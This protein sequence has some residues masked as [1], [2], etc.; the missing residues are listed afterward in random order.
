MRPLTP[1]EE[2][3]MRGRSVPAL[4]L[5]ALLVACGG[6]EPAPEYDRASTFEALGI[7][8]AETEADLREQLGTLDAVVIDPP[9]DVGKDYFPEFPEALPFDPSEWETNDSPPSI[10]DPR[11]KKGGRI[12]LATTDW[13]PT[14]RTEGPN[15][16]LAFLSNLHAMI[17]ET[18]LG[19]DPVGMEYVP[20]PRPL[21]A[22]RRRQDDLPVPHRRAGAV[23]RR[24][25]GHRRRRRRVRR[26]LPEP[27]P[28]GPPRQQVLGRDGRVREDARQVH[29]R[30]QDP[31]APL[32]LA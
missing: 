18:L 14:I 29:R 4:A 5:L 2:I 8:G 11:A 13:P 32:A 12:V 1:R 16:R 19:F 25:R 26:A 7:P 23:G 31:A 30:D 20:E 10:A 17:Y 9:P 27:G 22:G 24:P 21:L 3:A 28:Q 6:S 15:S